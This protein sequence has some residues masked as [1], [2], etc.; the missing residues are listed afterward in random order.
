MFRKWH[1]VS[2]H[3][4]SYIKSETS[5]IWRIGAQFLKPFGER[6]EENHNKTEFYSTNMEHIEGVTYA[7]KFFWKM[8]K[9][10]LRAKFEALT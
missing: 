4:V 3:C 5:D 10:S 9:L 8:E 6:F 2:Y 7:T 1:N